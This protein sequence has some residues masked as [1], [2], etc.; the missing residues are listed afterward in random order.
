MSTPQLCSSLL[1]PPSLRRSFYS[2]ST[3]LLLTNPTAKVLSFYFCRRSLV[4]VTAMDKSNTNA[5]E[6]SPEHVAGIWYSVPEL[7]LRD[8][9][10]TVPLDY[11]IDR[12]ASPKISIFAREVVAGGVWSV[13]VWICFVDFYHINSLLRVWIY[14]NCCFELLSCFIVYAALM[15]SWISWLHISALACFSAEKFG[16]KRREWTCFM[17]YFRY[18]DLSERKSR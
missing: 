2:A 18:L 4:T 13:F 5:T 3:H 1:K 7:R 14:S 6:A 11:S 9:R 10:F 15:S 8:H 12:S 16:R 17:L